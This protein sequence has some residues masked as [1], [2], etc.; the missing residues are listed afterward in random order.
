M[1]SCFPILP[2]PGHSLC[3]PPPFGVARLSVCHFLRFHI[4][5]PSKTSLVILFLI[6]SGSG[7]LS[8]RLLFSNGDSD[9]SLAMPTN[10]GQRSTPSSTTILCWLTIPAPGQQPS[11]GQPF[12]ALGQQ[13]PLGHPLP[14]FAALFPIPSNAQNILVHL[15]S[16]VAVGSLWL[17]MLVPY[18]GAVYDAPITDVSAAF[19][20][21]MSKALTNMPRMPTQ[22][23]RRMFL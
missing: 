11:L 6:R 15:L 9:L 3:P 8:F 7:S 17:G 4:L 13:P 16:T 14:R 5:R 18:K 19:Q 2:C 10:L 22:A 20:N 23:P 21:A 1:L 12:S